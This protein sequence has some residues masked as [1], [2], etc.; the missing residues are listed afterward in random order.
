M[1]VRQGAR[2]HFGLS[3]HTFIYLPGS[4]EFAKNARQGAFHAGHR[5]AGP[6]PRLLRCG[7]WLHLRLRTTLD[8]GAD[9]D[10]FSSREPV[11][12]SPEIDLEEYIH[13]LRLFT[14]RSRLPGAA[15]LPDLRPAAARA[16]LTA[17]ETRSGSGPGPN[18]RLQ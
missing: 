16:V 15:V 3:Q 4:A 12:A 11:T 6:R 14:R 2:S 13:D 10:A 1:R 8:L 7:D 18:R 5:H 9:L 17:E